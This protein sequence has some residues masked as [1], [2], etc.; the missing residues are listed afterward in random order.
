MN[1]KYVVP[2]ILLV[3]AGVAAVVFLE[4]PR[5]KVLRALISQKPFTY[6]G[7][8]QEAIRKA[9][10]LV[11]RDGGYDCCGKV[12]ADT[13][14]FAITNATELLQVATNLQFAPFTTTNSLFDSCMCCGFPGIDW[15]RGDRRLALTA[16]QHGKRLR[17][18]G[19]TTMRIAWVFKAGYGDA[20]LTPAAS[21]WLV[22]WLASHGVDGPKKEMAEATR[23]RE[24]HS[25]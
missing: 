10:R 24:E 14:L 20:P 6:R 11:V 12:D 17:W 22:D 9:D 3:L 21:Q 25:P 19:F 5:E 13:V 8:F 7:Q 2:L 23:K 16:V 4:K 1:A 15:Y 18:K